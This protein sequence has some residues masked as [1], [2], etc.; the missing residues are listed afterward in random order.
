MTTN[1]TAILD[2][3]INSRP[4]ECPSEGSPFSLANAVATVIALLSLAVAVFGSYL[5]YKSYKVTKSKEKEAS[6]FLVTLEEE[7][8][9]DGVP[10][11]QSQAAST[12]FQKHTGVLVTYHVLGLLRRHLHMSE[13]GT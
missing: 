1:G 6:D 2:L 11:I 7:D 10:S 3:I 5:N 9:V 13:V 4:S 8:E 12:R